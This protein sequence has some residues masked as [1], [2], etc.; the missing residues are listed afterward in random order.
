M[1]SRIINKAK[2][3]LF[4]IRF[5]PL[6][7]LRPQYSTLGLYYGRAQWVLYHEMVYLERI[8]SK[9]KI[10]TC[11]N[12]PYQYLENQVVFLPSAHHLCHAISISERPGKITGAFFHGIPK[13]GNPE[14]DDRFKIIKNKH[15]LIDRVQITNQRFKDLFHEETG[16]PEEKVQLI[17]IGIDTSLFQPCSFETK[18]NLRKK[19]SIPQ[20]AVVIGSMQKD[21][22]GWQKGNLPKWVKGPDILLKT[23][24]HLR[25]NVP[26]LFV[27]LSGPSRGYV[28]AG[29]DA[30]K[31]P[32]RN[33]L[34][35]NYHEMP[36]LYHCLDLCLVTSRDE[37]GPKAVMESMA[38]GVPIVST[39]VGM[40][41]ELIEHQINGWLADLE[42]FEHLSFCCVEA[43]EMSQPERVRILKKARE[44]ALSI[45]YDQLL[46]KWNAFF[47]GILCY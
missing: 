16:I 38:C 11:S 31:I 34:L 45:S 46:P 4:H 44:T 27:L 10:P 42:D 26:E 33:V 6:L 47:D 9:L 23:L 21:G 28:K 15:H 1:I 43:I 35:S 2:S 24:T 41:Q 14:F 39:K 17:P 22:A 5:A 12:V 32:Y 25:E 13:K 8:L 29:L 36:S 3:A 18:K 30:A 7:Y 37:G 40:A 20:N 19:Y